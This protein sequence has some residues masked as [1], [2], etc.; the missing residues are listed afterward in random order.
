[1]LRAVEYHR[2]H[3]RRGWFL[4][5]V[6]ALT[7]LPSC[8]LDQVILESAA[9]AKTSDQ[10]TKDVLLLDS[11]AR[12][13]QIRRRIGIL[14]SHRF[15]I[16][17][18]ESPRMAELR[19]PGSYATF[20]INV[21]QRCNLTCPYCYVN[22]GFFDYEEAPIPRMEAATAEQIVERIHGSFPGFKVY[23]YHF[24]GGEPLMNFDA[25][26][27][28]VAQAETLAK[29]T[30]TRT[31]YHIT[32]NGTLLSRNIADFMDAHRFT[33]YF[34]I[35]GDQEN[36][37]ELRRYTNGRGS[38]RDVERNLEY[39]RTRPG[40]HLIGSSVIRAGF[41]LGEAI[42]LLEGHGARQCK[43]ERVRLHDSDS[44]G[45]QGSEHDDYLNDIEGLTDHYV[46]YLES[47]RK[48]MDF[49]LS[50]KILQ[51][52]T[53]VR[54]SFFCPAGERMFGVSA[55]GEIYP[56][57]LHV[58]RPQSKLGDVANGIDIEKQ[59]AFRQRFSP[60]GQEVCRACW[61]R[62]LCGGGCS[63]MVDRFGHEDCQA[64][65]AE[66]EAAIAVYQHFAE[67][68]PALLYGLV[69]PK[70]AKWATGRLDDPDELYPSEPAALPG[71][72]Q[73]H[74][75]NPGGNTDAK[76]LYNLTYRP[77]STLVTS[78]H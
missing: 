61:N 2:F 59:K 76:P 22:K 1:L 69:S 72:C 39:L 70:I 9:T 75:D 27:R 45:L 51:I 20:M 42:G 28:I 68:E 73:C 52:L 49:R 18:D 3:S 5:D 24:Y 58:G 43:A 12:K 23:G 74:G 25:I 56:C 26:R 4:F 48:P 71:G 15:L 36:H 17:Q 41:S 7:V 35:D 66:S 10:L 54:R 77:A 60:Q 32:T 31:D 34:S 38:Y 64:L 6:N 40:V 57:A 13:A 14:A 78:D 65:M 67:R 62:H 29:R 46:A 50:S 33:V 11:T 16:P 44:L 19:E 37:D 53:R 21:A 55:D 47:G 30:G 8:P 63:A